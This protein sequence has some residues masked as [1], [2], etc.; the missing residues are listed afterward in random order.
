MYVPIVNVRRPS[1]RLRRLEYRSC[2]A[3][4]KGESPDRDCRSVPSDTGVRAI[5]ITLLGEPAAQ[6]KSAAA[7]IVRIAAVMQR[8]QVHVPGRTDAGPQRF[9][10]QTPLLVRLQQKNSDL[11]LADRSPKA[12]EIALADQRAVQPMPNGDH[13]LASFVP[14]RPQSHDQRLGIDH[15]TE[16]KHRI[17]QDL[18]QSFAFGADCS[19]QLAGVRRLVTSEYEVRGKNPRQ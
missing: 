3:Q 2:L 4:R 17:C 12:S 16:R 19:Q 5:A 9:L 1:W 6:R 7:Q 15:G 10:G 13:E 14:I 8:M 18:A 11:S